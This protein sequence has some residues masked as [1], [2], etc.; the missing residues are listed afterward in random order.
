MAYERAHQPAC[1]YEWYEWARFTSAELTLRQFDARGRL[2][3][4]W[5]LALQRRLDE[6]RGFIICELAPEQ[7]VEVQRLL[8]QL[9][10]AAPGRQPRCQFEWREQMLLNLA[11]RDIVVSYCPITALTL[12]V[13]DSAEVIVQVGDAPGLTRQ[14]GQWQLDRALLPRE[15]LAVRL[16]CAGL[17]AADAL[18]LTAAGE[19]PEARRPLR[20]VSPT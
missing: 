8:L 1:A 13:E 19:L 2:R 6:A 4:E 18:A 12:R 10:R 3:H 5:P 9:A 11:D 20:M 17:T 7:P 14:G 15:V 16:R